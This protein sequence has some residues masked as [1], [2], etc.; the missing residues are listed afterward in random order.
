[1]QGP[2]DSPSTPTRRKI[3]EPT[4]DWKGALEV[5]KKCCAK[6]DEPAE[7]EEALETQ[8]TEALQLLTERYEN[9]GLPGVSVANC[10]LSSVR[11]V[12]RSYVSASGDLTSARQI[13]ER[14]DG[15]IKSVY[16]FPSQG[17]ERRSAS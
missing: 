13:E 12:P 1:M 9:L 16:V 15:V 17:R 7:S 11:M 6:F 8:S 10:Q 2:A 3:L 5:A 14:V 4:A